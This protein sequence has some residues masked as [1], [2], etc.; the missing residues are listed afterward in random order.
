M[1]AHVCV[2]ACVCVCVRAPISEC[3]GLTTAVGGVSAAYLEMAAANGMV[4]GL[5]RDHGGGAF[6]SFVALTA[7]CV[8]PPPPMPS[9][10]GRAFLQR[11]TMVQPFLDVLREYQ[12]FLPGCAVRG[13]VS[14]RPTS[15][16]GMGC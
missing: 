4:V 3:K 8:P 2:R 6:R 10:G 13:A 7:G 12:T 15:I 9:L 16:A 14:V 1:C 11:K 5:D